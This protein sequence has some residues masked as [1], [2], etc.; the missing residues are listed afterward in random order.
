[1]TENGEDIFLSFC[2]QNRLH[3]TVW[4]HT[5]SSCHTQELHLDRLVGW[6]MFCQTVRMMASQRRWK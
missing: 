4:H 5:S 6:C 1:V 3:R 2:F